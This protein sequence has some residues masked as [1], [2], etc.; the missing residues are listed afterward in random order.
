MPRTSTPAVSVTSDIEVTFGA[1]ER[2]KFRV[3]YMSAVLNTRDINDWIQL[4]VEDT[5]Y[6]DQ[7]WNIESLYQRDLDQ[8]RVIQIAREYL[9]DNQNNRPAFFNSL[10]VVLMKKDMPA[11]NYVAPALIKKPEYPETREIGPIRIC[12]ERTSQGKKYPAACSFGTLSWNRSQVRAV[13]IDGQH[14]LAALKQFFSNDA[15][16]AEKLSVSVLFL[17]IDEKLGFIA[18]SSTKSEQVKYMR[19]IFIDLNK[20]AVPVSRARNILLDDRDPQALILKGLLGENLTYSPT[21]NNNRWGLK[22]GKA[23]EF[24]SNIPLSLVDWHGETRSKIDQGPYLSSILS[25]DWIVRKVLSSKGHPPQ[26]LLDLSKYSIDDQDYYVNVRKVVRNWK[27]VWR[28]SDKDIEFAE[29]S[30]SQFFFSEVALE[31]AQQEFIKLWGYPLVRLLTALQPYKTLIKARL[32]HKTLTAQFSQWYQAVD[33]FEMYK[34]RDD[35]VTAHYKK[36]LQDVETTLRDAQYDIAKFRATLDSC[37]KVKRKADIPYFLV[38][39]R[40]LVFS[41]VGLV[42]TNDAAT[43]CKSIGQNINKYK[44]SPNDFYAYFLVEALNQIEHSLGGN[45]SIFKKVQRFHSGKGKLSDLSRNLWAGSICKR[46]KSD[47]IDYS[48][49]AALRASKIYLLLTFL[50]WFKRKNPTVTATEVKEAIQDPGKLSNKEFGKQV[51]VSLKELRGEIDNNNYD[52]PFGYHVKRLENNASD[53]HLDE[54]VEA[55]VDWCFKNF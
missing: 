13:A 27:Q 18:P 41:L 52:S 8:H 37:L 11:T 49:K 16:S 9:G 29:R 38:G 19:S 6:V 25:L 26:K 1:F 12:F 4:V 22:K 20:H 24:D 43:W 45:K 30:N 35:A 32:T 28:A 40:A 14:R 39:Q 54:L 36:N 47:E 3:P 44:Y 7:D 15:D 10:T 55:L 48:E 42:S 46:D 31:K 50:Y 33:Q 23:R 5:K 53:D 51:T 2:G 34:K 17:V 21:R